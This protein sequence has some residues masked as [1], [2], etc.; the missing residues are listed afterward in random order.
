MISLKTLKDKIDE[1]NFPYFSDDQLNERIAELNTGKLTQN[2]LIIQLLSIKS[3][4]PEIKLGDV[5]IP[6]PRAHFE[7]LIRR[8]RGNVSRKV[9][10]ADEDF[11]RK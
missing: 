9:G 4:I 7:A 6:S 5:I 10:R 1:E 8:Y 11:T 2:E 3:N